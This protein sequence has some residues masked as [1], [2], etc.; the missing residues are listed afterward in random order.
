MLSSD[1]SD[2]IVSRI[3]KLLRSAAGKVQ[4]LKRSVRDFIKDQELVCLIV[5]AQRAQR[6][7]RSEQ[8]RGQSPVLFPETFGPR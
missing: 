8:R 2:S 1:R 5:M 3:W 6:E 4:Q 7:P